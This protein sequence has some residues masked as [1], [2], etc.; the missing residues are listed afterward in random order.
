MTRS[1]IKNGKSN[2]HLLFVLFQDSTKCHKC[3]EYYWPDADKVKCSAAVEEFLS[4]N[5]AVGIV[6]VTLTLLGVLLTVAITLVFHCYRYTPIVKANNSEMSFLLLLSLKLCFLCSLAF[7]GRPA[8][9]TCRLRQ[10]AFGISFV[11]CLSCLL[12]KTIVVLSAFRT[13]SPGQREFKLF[14]P[15]QQRTLIFCTTAPQVK[16]LQSNFFHSLLTHNFI[17]LA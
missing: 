1:P 13:C 10:A 17:C 3:P 7:I 4:M 5:D 11:L 16:E 15:S 14:G 12:V 2:S 6:L 8:A 9:W